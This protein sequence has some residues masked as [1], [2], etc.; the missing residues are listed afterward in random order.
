[1]N[2]VELDRAVEILQKNKNHWA[3]LP[4]MEK[5]RLAGQ[6][7][8]GVLAV[9]DRLVAKAL[10][11]KGVPPSSPQSAE[12]WL[13]GPLIVLRNL[14]LLRESLRQI[15][16]YGV[17]QIHLE[18]I[19]TRP[20]GQVAVEVF[21]YDIFDRLLYRGFHAEVWMQPDVHSDQLSGTMASFYKQSQPEG[22][23]SLILG[24]GNVSS[25]A[26]LDVIY[27]LF[28]EGRVCL[29]KPSPINDYIGAFV[30]EAFSSFIQEG[31]LQVVYGAADVGAYLCEHSGVDEIHITGS[32]ETHDTIVF[33]AGREGAERKFRKQ[34][35]LMKRIT[36]ELGNVSPV[37]VVPGNWSRS[38]LKFQAENV[39]T[40]MTN[41]AGLNCNAAKVL[42]THANW[43][44]RIAFLDTLRNVLRVLPT[45]RVYYPG[46]FCRY[47]RFIESHSQAEIFGSRSEETLPWTFIP[48][49]NPQRQDDV[50]FAQ[51]AFC[52]IMAETP[53]PSGNVVDFLR[54]AVHFC[55]K[56]LWGT[57][58]A[59]VIIHPNVEAELGAFLDEAISDL[60]YG[61]VA[62]NHWPALSYAFG[63][64]TWGAYPGHTPDDIQSGVGV[65][66]NTLMFGKSQ[67]SV[68][69]GPFRMW[70]K[71]A[72]FVT[73]RSAHKLAPI[74]TRFEARPRWLLIPPLMWHGLR[75]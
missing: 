72:W 32:A 13:A 2:T 37:I 53:F 58:N 1:M 42:I 28:V 44:Q 38:D 24:A 55:N 21:P 33:G 6:L 50:C 54:Q 48:S 68:I 43:A 52:G 56:T 4:V 47:T 63:L 10:G 14:R 30:E 41:N 65:V 74:L 57:L 9:A 19:R 36:S 49:I 23:V 61:S 45:R 15:A 17:P 60:R 59:C 18:K 40:Q 16:R 51:E 27:K 35:R 62:I 75:G 69:Y 8:Q 7:I 46:T 71:P 11:A 34:P 70:P 26:P 5:E 20:N 66:H 22:K 29:L 39:A 73:H 3:N 25:I 12:E 31:Y 67:K 64:T